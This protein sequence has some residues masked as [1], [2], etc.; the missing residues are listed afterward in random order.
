MK[1]FASIALVLILMLGI[2]SCIRFPRLDDEDYGDMSDLI[3]VENQDEIELDDFFDLDVLIEGGIDVNISNSEDGFNYIQ[4]Q[5]GNE[6]LRNSSYG[7]IDGTLV[8]RKLSRRNFISQGGTINIIVAAEEIG[9]FRLD[10]SGASRVNVNPLIDEADI[11][12]AGAGELIF[13]DVRNLD[14]DFSGATTSEF[15]EVGDFNV[16]ISGAGSVSI[17]SASG[18]GY[19]EAAGAAE[20]KLGESTMGD[21]T[22]NFAG[23]ARFESDASVNNL[24]VDMAG[25]GHVSVREVRGT[26]NLEDALFGTVEIG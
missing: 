7:V 18:D 21:L 15:N 20:M 6:F 10:I 4:F 3:P 8:V 9:D 22:L 25:A 24:T 5:G 2:S 12:V 16:D 19:F 14:I 23:A 17:N 11:E 1:K 13:N 26:Q